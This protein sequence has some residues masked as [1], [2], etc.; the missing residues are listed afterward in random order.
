M[1][2]TDGMD[3]LDS[4]LGSL[5]LEKELKN[6]IREEVKAAQEKE[7]NRRYVICLVAVVFYSGYFWLYPRRKG[8]MFNMLDTLV[9]SLHLPAFPSLQKGWTRYIPMFVEVYTA[10]CLCTW[11]WEI[12]VE[13]FGNSEEDEEDEIFV[14]T[15][16]MEEHGDMVDCDGS[17]I[18]YQQDIVAEIEETFQERYKQLE[19]DLEERY[20]HDLEDHIKRSK[21]EQRSKSSN[22][23]SVAGVNKKTSQ[24][25]IESQQKAFTDAIPPKNGAFQTHR[26][27]GHKPQGRAGVSSRDPFEH[28]HCN[29]FRHRKE[30]WRSAIAVAY[31]TR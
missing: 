26:R 14:C 31:R 20:K 17:P 22:S 23:R 28:N 4:P 24:I 1:S 15:D 10:E 12:L 18:I 25:F 6:R 21:K 16:C 13:F 27:A 5:V 8:Y 2:R 11:I 29:Y 7:M 30:N 9:R 3:T 19:H